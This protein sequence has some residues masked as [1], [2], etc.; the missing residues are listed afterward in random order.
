MP[1]LS[2]LALTLLAA[3]PIEADIVLRGGTIY[4]GGTGEGVVGDVAIKGDRIVAIGKFELAGTPDIIEVK[5]LIVAPGFIDLHTHS[6]TPI[7]QAETKQNA[8]YL[9]QGVTSIVT[10][11]CGFGPVD[12]AAYLAKI[13]EQ[14]AGTNVLHLVPHGSLR[15]K[16]MDDANRPPT[17]DELD[18]M[19]D[20]AAAGMQ[21]GAWG[22][23]TGLIYTPGS[24]SQTD[25]LVSL[26][27]VIGQHGGIY[28]S[29][30]R[31]EGNQLLESFDEI[32]AIGR[33]AKLPV[34]VSHIKVTG[35]PNWGLARDGIAKL[36]EARAA[37]QRVT[38][39]QYPYIASSTSLAA[40]LIP[41]ELRSWPKLKA[42]LDDPEQGPKVR[43][44]IERS[45]ADKDGGAAVVVASFADQRAW[46]GKSLAKIAQETGQSPL[47]VVLSIMERGGCSI[48]NFGMNEDEVRL[49]MREPWVATASDGSAMSLTAPTQPHPRSFG[50]FPRKIGRYAIEGKFIPLGQAIRSASGLP[51]DILSLPERGY[52]KPGYFA[53]VVVFDPATY[54]DNATFEKPLQWASGVRLVLVNGQIAVENEKPTDELAGRALRHNVVGPNAVGQASRLPNP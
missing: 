11:N 24:F 20:L 12:V 22:M 4:D 15:Q 47:A 9:L 50:T 21:D 8:N 34:H 18:K 6:D 1:A 25:E 19:R 52:L 32:L 28:A 17:P 27:E 33:K 31:N 13:E 16:V 49:F 45:L 23:A 5:G 53:D 26:A 40:T 36:N 29:H 46:Q 41:D 48:V 10:G 14:G 35:R 2:W 39:D 44:R 3:A 51:A 54:R 42:A 38:A 30:V 7:T 43:A 37:G